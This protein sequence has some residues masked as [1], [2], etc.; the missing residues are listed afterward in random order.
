M[1]LLSA[2]AYNGATKEEEVSY[3]TL[4]TCIKNVCIQKCICPAAFKR[5]LTEDFMHSYDFFTYSDTVWRK[6]NWMTI[7]LLFREE[8]FH[9]SSV[10]SLTESKADCFY[11]NGP[12]VDWWSV[13]S[14]VKTDVQP[15][16]SLPGLSHH[17]LV[18]VCVSLRACTRVSLYMHTCLPPVRYNSQFHI[19]QDSV[20]REGG[21]HSVCCW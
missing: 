16:T 19:L 10:T 17:I 15:P 4:L 21:T 7:N 12:P 5:T 14:V 3:T 2:T 18:C 1:L 20:M 8:E 9:Q 13:L 11:S 6:E